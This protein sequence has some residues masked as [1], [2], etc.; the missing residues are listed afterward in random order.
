MPLSNYYKSL[1][2]LN[3]I[4]FY[5]RVW[6][7]AGNNVLGI[8]F[9]QTSYKLKFDVLKYFYNRNTVPRMVPVCVF[10]TIRL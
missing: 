1:R 2:F 6:C 7:F 3:G 4:T 8:K 5:L 9:N 10:K